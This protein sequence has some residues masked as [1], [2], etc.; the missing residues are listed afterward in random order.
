M[1]FI[2]VFGSLAAIVVRKSEKRHGEVV[3]S[4]IPLKILFVLMLCFPFSVCCPPLC[5]VT[6]PLTLLLCTTVGGLL[7]YWMSS[8]SDALLILEEASFEGA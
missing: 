6:L 7:S 5:A 2:S 8:I 4:F 1:D 3:A